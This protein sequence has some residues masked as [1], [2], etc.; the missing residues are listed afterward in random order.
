MDEPL[1]TTPAGAPVERR[2]GVLLVLPTFDEA[3]SLERVVDAVLASPA[4]VDVLIVDD[5]S[6][7][8]T[9]DIA[10]RIAAAE[11]RVT[12]LH[13]PRR[14]GL[15]SAYLRGFEIAAERGADAVVE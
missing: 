12:V 1:A 8:G 5:S 14:S 6:P 10:D 4:G 15:G 2:G 3:E 11:P 9:G 13:R 7:D